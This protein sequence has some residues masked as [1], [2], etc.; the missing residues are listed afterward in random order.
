MAIDAATHLRVSKKV[1]LVP[2][3]KINI[4]K[5]NVYY[6]TDQLHTNLVQPIASRGPLPLPLQPLPPLLDG[7]S[8]HVEV[9]VHTPPHMEYTCR[10]DE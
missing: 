4:T 1:V 7:I 2:T 5:S 6:V 3:F 8:D 10:R 9:Y